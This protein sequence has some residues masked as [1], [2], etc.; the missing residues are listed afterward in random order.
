MQQAC[1]LPTKQINL[2]NRYVL[3]A[4]LSR[5]L[6]VLCL[7]HQFL[8]Q[9]CFSSYVHCFSSES[10]KLYGVDRERTP[11]EQR[12]LFSVLFQFSC[13]PS[14]SCFVVDLVMSNLKRNV[15]WTTEKNASICSKISLYICD[16]G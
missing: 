2:T 16:A 12:G 4:T 1:F 3:Q 13:V 7:W 11:Q 14:L 5:R 10:T 15:M 9:T 8:E 6:P